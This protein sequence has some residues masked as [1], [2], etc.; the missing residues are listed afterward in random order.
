MDELYMAQISWTLTSWGVSTDRT[1]IMY[2]EA[3]DYLFYFIFN[4]QSECTFYKL[5]SWISM[6]WWGV[7]QRR[8]LGT[9]DQVNWPVS[10]MSSLS[11]SIFKNGFSCVL[12]LLWCLLLLSWMTSCAE[13]MP[14]SAWSRHIMVHLLSFVESYIGF[15]GL[16][17]YWICLRNPIILGRTSKY[18]W[19]WPYKL[20]F[21]SRLLVFI[22]RL[23]AASTM[24]SAVVQ[25]SALEWP[26]SRI[27][28]N[29]GSRNLHVSDYV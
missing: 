7:V 25:I 15:S 1:S 12:I 22:F 20:G 13:D 27:Q 11:S 23:A 6:A 8:N 4:Q 2:E 17:M 24:R 16:L 21:Y 19:L 14:R 28:N 26:G 3:L 5:M 9:L 10:Y 29:G 18:V